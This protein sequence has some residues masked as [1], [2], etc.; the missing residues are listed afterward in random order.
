MSDFINE[1]LNQSKC[2]FY[3]VQRE[4]YIEPIEE[5][6]NMLDINVGT[7]YRSLEMSDDNDLQIHLNGLHIHVL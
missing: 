6:L 1:Y 4:D 5:I 2:N 7:Y 3:D